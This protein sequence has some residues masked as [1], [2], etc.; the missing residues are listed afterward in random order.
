MKTISLKEFLVKLESADIITLG[1]HPTLCY[2]NKD[3]SDFF[4]MFIGDEIIIFNKRD[5]Q[6]IP[7]YDSEGSTYSFANLV[8]D[9]GRVMDVSLYSYM[10]L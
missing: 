9:T 5:N 2:G 10:Q 4:E 3:E 1:G 6:I 8:T 7:V